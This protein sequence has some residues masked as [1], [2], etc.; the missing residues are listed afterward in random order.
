MDRRWSLCTVAWRCRTNH[1]TYPVAAAHDRYPWAGAEKTH[2]A[3]R[4][5]A[6]DSANDA[7]LDLGMTATM[8]MPMCFFVE[9]MLQRNAAAKVILGTRVPGQVSL[10]G[11]GQKNIHTA[12]AI[13]AGC[14]RLFF[15]HGG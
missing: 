5:A 9:E 3:T 12:P 10:G 13:G 1:A 8:E 11:R 4:E 14:V 6:L 7:I 15:L 2:I